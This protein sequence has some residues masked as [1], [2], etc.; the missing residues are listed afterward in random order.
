VLGAV[1]LA[2]G[3]SD[4]DGDT[5]APPIATV[6]DIEIAE[7]DVEELASDEGFL[8][9]IGAPS[10]GDG[11]EDDE[12]ELSDTEAGRRTLTW[13][14]GKAL[15]DS[16]LDDAGVEVSDDARDQAEDDLEAEDLPPAVNAIVDGDEELGRDASDTVADALAAWVTLDE[17][18]RSLDPADEE[19]HARIV[20]AH[21][22]VADS[23]CG[24]ALSVDEADAVTVR[25][26]LAAGASLDQIAGTVTALS[27]TSPGGECLSRGSYPR[28]LVDVLNGTPVGSAG[29]KTFTSVSTGEPV[30]FFVT[31]TLQ[32]AVEGDLLDA[33]VAST[34]ER[35]HDEGGAAFGELAYSTVDPQLDAAWGT[36]DPAVGVVAADSEPTWTSFPLPEPTTT[37]ATPPPPP[38][39]AASSQF[40]TG[41]AATLGGGSSAD[42][43]TGDLVARAQAA[44]DS[45]IPVV[46]RDA[47]PVQLSII[48]GPTS[49]SAPDGTIQ[50]GSVHATGEWDRLRAVMGHE[51]GHQVGFF[52]GSQEHNGA[53][54][55]GWPPSGYTP[56]E[57]AWAD[58]VSA[59]YFAYYPCGGSSQAWTA[60]WM[61]QGPGAHPRTA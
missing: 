8:E 6:H 42:P 45:M 28:Q 54:P 15:I 50:V 36:W 32:V 22:E 9:F 29:E 4:D 24:S 58:C 46:W 48:E 26:Q 19:L 25:D 13:L 39:P 5:G 14:I 44:L 35:L 1:L 60:D 7:S 10:P 34:V 11:D 56:P 61:G 59:S 12:A 41:S 2:P 52:Y 33:V 31:P 23:I 17:H 55:T 40:V 49:W 20:E 18:L 47:L 37:T 53:A 16:A 30:V 21:P 43:G 38:P 57:E 3:C 27:S 51:F